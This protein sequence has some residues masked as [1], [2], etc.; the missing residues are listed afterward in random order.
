MQP[1][2]RTMAKASV[3]N[4]NRF[5][6]GIGSSVGIL[7]WSLQ[8]G[9]Q[10]EIGTDSP[11][12]KVGIHGVPALKLQLIQLGLEHSH[13]ISLKVHGFI[14]TGISAGRGG[15]GTGATAGTKSSQ[16]QRQQT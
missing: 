11:D 9:I 8:C 3:R 12:R 10:N 16:N 1:V 5:F 4:K 14:F 2:P 7:P 15:F 13:G 6:I